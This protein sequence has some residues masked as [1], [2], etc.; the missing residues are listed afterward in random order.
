MASDL[1]L[2]LASF[3]MIALVVF[4]FALIVIKVFDSRVFDMNGK[5]LPGPSNH[6]WGDNFFSFLVKARIEYKQISKAIYEIFLPKCGDG[7][8]VR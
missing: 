4:F 2:W 3:L 5:R 1:E 7:N 8:I 6:L